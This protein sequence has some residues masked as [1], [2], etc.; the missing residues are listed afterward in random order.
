MEVIKEVTCLTDEI[1]PSL[2]LENPKDLNGSTKPVSKK[3]REEASLDH[4][5]DSLLID[6]KAEQ[7]QFAGKGNSLQK[8]N[9]KD[10]ILFSTKVVNGVNSLDVAFQ[11]RNPKSSRFKIGSSRSARVGTRQTSIK[12]EEVSEK[13]PKPSEEP[14]KA[15]ANQSKPSNRC[16]K[17]II[18]EEREN[19]VELPEEYLAFTKLPRSPDESVRLRR[20]RRPETP[21]PVTR[22]YT[23]KYKE[24][25]APG[26]IL[27]KKGENKRLF[28]CYKDELVNRFENERDAKLMHHP[29]IDED[30]SSNE[31]QIRKASIRVLESLYDKVDRMKRK[32]SASRVNKPYEQASTIYHKT[33]PQDA[34]NWHVIVPATLPVSA[35]PSKPQKQEGKKVKNSSPPK[36]SAE[37]RH[38][39]LLQKS[40]AEQ[41]AALERARVKYKEKKKLARQAKKDKE[42]MGSNLAKP[43][44]NPKYNVSKNEPPL[45]NNRTTIIK[46]LKAPHTVARPESVPPKQDSEKHQTCS[47][48]VKPEMGRAGQAAGRSTQPTRIT[49]SDPEN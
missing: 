38:L 17:R 14:P 26:P 23:L 35:P 48:S 1:N 27:L 34:Q 15:P 33:V 19:S 36:T 7:V 44:E 4:S 49:P 20:R 29:K 22:F 28:H 39:E 12:K 9:S 10:N 16:I 25:T 46:E 37:R 45:V 13:L 30:N 3:S 2:D 5:D 40:A 31:S 43:A 8:S 24:M 21:S 32:N 11:E 6:P 18:V 41:R 47:K 42:P